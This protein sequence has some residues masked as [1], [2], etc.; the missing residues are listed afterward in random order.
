MR[1]L[2]MKKYFGEIEDSIQQQKI[3]YNLVEVIV[4]TII[5]V[6]AGAEHWN[7]IA[8]Y[9]KSKENIFREKHGLILENGV[10]TN[11][12]FQRI[13]AIINP[14]QLYVYYIKIYLQSQVLGCKNNKNRNRRYSYKI[15][16]DKCGIIID[17]K[18]TQN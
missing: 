16:L 10:P 1:K 8:M 6:T 14:E 3:K 2:I 17:F 7:E 18:F 13:F 9:C 5:A 11:D 12:T 15:K 4:M